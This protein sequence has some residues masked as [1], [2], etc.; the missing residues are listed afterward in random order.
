M[1]KI[2][3]NKIQVSKPNKHKIETQTTVTKIKYPSQL[4]AKANKEQFQKHK[5]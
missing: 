3:K 1:P 4:S 5:K 2:C